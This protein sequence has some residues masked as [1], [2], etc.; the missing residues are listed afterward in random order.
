MAV[1]IEGISVVI[2][3]DAILRAFGEFE[4]FKAVVP[5]NTLCADSE[6]AR[7]G[8]M[9]PS[10]VRDFIVRLEQFGLRFLVDSNAIDMVV[11]DQQKGLAARCDWVECGQINW[12]GDP[13]KRVAGARLIDS[14]VGQIVTPNGWTFEESLS[15]SFGFIP[16]A[17]EAHIEL[18]EDRDSLQTFRSSLTTKP[19]YVGRTRRNQRHLSR[20]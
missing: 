20:G 5:N 16:T 4:R 11:I 13:S 9:H 3:A 19:L 17:S 10:D 6:L 15:S 2:R 14:K 8:F 18:I 12:G 7:V 1:L